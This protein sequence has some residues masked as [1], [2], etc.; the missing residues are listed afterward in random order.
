VKVNF[1]VAI[2]FITGIVA[3][4]A[5]LQGLRAQAKPPAYQVIEVDVKDPDLYKQYQAK[6]M[7]L[8]LQHSARFIARGGKLEAFAGEPPKRAVIAIYDSI[9]MVQALRDSPEYKAIV[10]L[11]EKAANYRSYIVEGA[12]N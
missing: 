12:A 7:P 8:Q 3:G 9:E 6:A 1:K 10:P 2:A 11:R 5:T 4:I